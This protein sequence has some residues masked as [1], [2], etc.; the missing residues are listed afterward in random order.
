MRLVGERGL[1]RLRGA[2]EAAADR[3]RQSELG[4][5][6]LDLVD[7]VAERAAGR[8]VEGDRHRW[9]LA[10]VVD[11]EG[12]GRRRVAGE[13]RERHE[14][15]VARRG[16]ARTSRPSRVLPELRVHL[17]DHVVLVERG[18]HRRDLALAE[19]VVERVVDGLRRDAEARGRR[20]VDRQRGLEAL[21]L[22]I[23]VD[24]GELGQLPQPLRAPRGAQ[25]SSSRTSSP[26]SVYWYCAALA[27]PPMRRSCTAWRKSVAPGTWASFGR[28]RAMI[29]VGRQL[30]L[31][32]GFSVTNMR[33]GV[34]DAAASRV[35]LH[36]A[37]RPG[38]A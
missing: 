12:R 7:R 31:A 14:R 25:S 2:L 24:V 15:A 9:E 32:G 27:R 26:W 29:C 19:G 21:D 3:G 13:R 16:R 34:R 17:H 38:P 37:R 20:A 33:A 18:V 23:A 8:Q 10:L 28:S 35:R 22:L 30:A 36:V 11:L 6:G 1:E 4:L 5:G